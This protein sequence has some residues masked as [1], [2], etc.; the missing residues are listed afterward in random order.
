[1]AQPRSGRP[2]KLTERD[3][4]V[5]KRVAKLTTEF[6]TDSGS[7][8][9]VI[10]VRGEHHDMGFHGRV[11]PQKPNHHAQCQMS[12]VVEMRS[13]SQTEV[14]LAVRQTELG[15]ADANRTLPALMHRA[16]CKVWWRRNNG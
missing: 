14:H 3:R 16:N 13:G 4:R 6:Q 7:N 10:T 5:L 12:G 9:S 1:M 15:L 2:H 11:A 8:V